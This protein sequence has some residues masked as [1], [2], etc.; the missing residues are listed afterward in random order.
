MVKKSI[1]WWAFF[2]IL[3]FE[4]NAM[5]YFALYIGDL[6]FV[7]RPIG[8]FYFDFDAADK[9]FYMR[10]DH[11]F[12]YPLSIVAGDDSFLLFK[13]SNEKDPKEQTIDQVNKLDFLLE[14]LEL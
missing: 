4:V 11:E 12:S 3:I 6:R 7:D 10:S 13:I 5:K 9:V 14:Q 8:E 1:A 2:G